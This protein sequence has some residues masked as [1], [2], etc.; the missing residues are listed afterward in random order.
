MISLPPTDRTKGLKKLPVETGRSLAGTATGINLI[1]GSDD[2]G[3]IIPPPVK[4]SDGTEIFLYKDG[5]AWHAAFEAMKRARF[6]ICLE[7][8]IFA[9]DETGQ[10]VAEL[11]CERARAGIRV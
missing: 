4:L 5:E 6:R 1:P 7:L 9:S 8:Y 3:W 10:A 2:D 11:L